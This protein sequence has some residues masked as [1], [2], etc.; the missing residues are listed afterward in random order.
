MKDLP[1]LNRVQLLVLQCASMLEEDKQGTES[2]MEDATSEI[3][4]MGLA[5]DSPE[6]CGLTDLG[7][8]ALAAFDAAERAKIRVEA[9]RECEVEAVEQSSY[10][11]GYCG[12]I[13]DA[14][15]EKIAKEQP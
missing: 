1:K 5:H 15:R 10:R 3:L 13:V 2:Q 9:M 4:A 11:C 7:R 12:A 14:I 8:A 6:K